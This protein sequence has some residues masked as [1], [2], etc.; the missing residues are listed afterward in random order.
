MACL[1]IEQG[2][3]ISMPKYGVKLRHGNDWAVCL[4][5]W[6][7]EYSDVRALRPTR[8]Y[9]EKREALTWMSQ[10]DHLCS[11]NRRMHGRKFRP[12]FIVTGSL[13]FAI[14]THGIKKIGETQTHTHLTFLL[15]K[16]MRVFLY[17]KLK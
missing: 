9:T 8:P 1:D 7:S 5:I 14:I 4:H 13:A 15:L 17:N 6:R 12:S 10:C 3:D 2:S 11:G 16:Y